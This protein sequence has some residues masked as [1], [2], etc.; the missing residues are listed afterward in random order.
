[1]S[2]FFKNVSFTFASNLICTLISV[3]VTFIL[4]KGISVENYGYFQLYFFYINYT[5]FL[6][7]GWA[8][9]LFLRHGG[10]YYESL[11]K[12]V[13]GS[14]F[15]I[16]W[17]IEILISLIFCFAALYL[18]DGPQRT[19]VFLLIG[20]S[21]AFN[22]PKTY[23]QYLLQATNRIKEYA[24]L[25]TLERI[26]FGLFILAIVCSG[27]DS[28]TLAI[29]ADLLG[30]LISLA[31]AIYNCRDLLAS[32]FILG[33]NV[34]KEIV[35]NINVG[36]KL[37]L[38]NIASLLI[39]GVV[40]WAIDQKWDVCTFGKISLTL[41]V[42]N[43]MM[44]FVRSVSMVMLPTLR[45][46]EGQKYASIYNDIKVILFTLMFGGLL[47]YYPLNVVLS[48]WLPN[49]ADSLKY[50][51]VLFPL[52]VF[53]GKL[54]ILVEMYLKT[55]RLEKQIL[56]SNIATLVFSIIATFVSVF[57]LENLSIAV[58]CMLVIFAFRTT[59]GEYLL[60]K[61]LNINFYRNIVVEM[62]LVVVFVCSSWLVSGIKGLLI[63]CG[64][65]VVF[66]LMYRKKIVSVLKERVL[67]KSSGMFLSKK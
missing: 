11:N 37:M 15:K 47:I 6:H 1:M 10:A 38:A 33:K 45:R 65:Y 43:I 35:S 31:Y 25:I 9:G 22:L 18:A 28:F 5:G 19:K 42:S 63:Y 36:S 54:S 62:A 60:S 32:R 53:E 13:F 40:R 4:P 23:L 49:Y 50:M 39:I 29:C 7:F 64:V 26:V 24:T 46:I 16:Y 66:L 41:S 2:S 14:Q 55:M 20:A 21:I 51:A 8:D 12:D 67:K 27:K 3:L 58:M 52:C 30:K 57:V 48:I 61:H 44:I 56:F 59:L 34:F 17:I